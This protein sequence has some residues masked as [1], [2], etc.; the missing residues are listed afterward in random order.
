M[1]KS[2][3]NFTGLSEDLINQSFNITLPPAL[4]LLGAE[5]LDPKDRENKR[6]RGRDTST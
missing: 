2:L 1:N 3:A 5:K 4:R 6:K